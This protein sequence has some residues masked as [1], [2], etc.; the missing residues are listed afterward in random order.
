[1]IS[2]QGV[3][4]S[5]PLTGLMDGV[6]TNNRLRA[7]MLKAA[8]RK[9][10]HWLVEVNRTGRPHRVQEDK[11]YTLRNML[12]SLDRALR[13]GRISRQAREAVLRIL[14]GKVFTE[15]PEIREIRRQSD[16]YAFPSFLTIS[17]GKACNLRCTGCYADSSAVNSEK[18]DFDLVDRIITEKTTKWNSHFTVISGGEPLM[19]RSQGK[20]ILDIAERHQDNYFLMYTNGTLIDRETAWRMAELGNITPAVS[21]EGFEEQTDKRRGKGAHRKILRAFKHLRE[22]GV[23][24]GISATATRYNAEI[25]VSDE[26]IDY[27]FDQEGAIYGWIFQYM[28]IGRRFT[29]NLMVTPEQRLMM[30]RREQELLVKRKVFIADFWNSGP[31]SNGCISAG[32]TGGYFHINWDGEVT[33]CVFVPYSTHNIIEVY[34]NGGDLDTVLNCPYF[35]AIRKWQASYGYMKPAEK[36]GNQIVPCVIRDHHKVFRRVAKRFGARPV[37]PDAKAA[38]EDQGYYEGLVAYGGE[39]D[40]LTRAIWRGEYLGQS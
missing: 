35:D 18:L 13:D 26:F 11:F 25:I 39:V 17:P 21:V 31:V 14:V 32:R 29:L 5:R 3:L 20:G 16:G 6:L 22:A 27:Y 30:Y 9:L 10:Y 40:R 12:Y 1:M 7:F 8:E 36:I 4:L 38:L 34:R 33:P 37:D 19:W 2:V 24:F 28:P 23:P 15:D